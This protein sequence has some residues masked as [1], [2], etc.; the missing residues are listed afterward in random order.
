MSDVNQRNI[1]HPEEIMVNQFEADICVIGSGIA[2][3]IVAKECLDAGLKVVMLE[4][5]SRVNG[6][7][8]LLR[9]LEQMLRDH[10]I[11][12]MAL[13][14][15]PARYGRSDCQ[16]VGNR[17]YHLRSLSLVAR[18]GSTLGWIGSS[19]R[20][21]PEDFRLGSLTGQG[22]DWPLSY[23]DLETYY[24]LAEKTL[25]VAGDECDSGHPPRS[26]P[27]PLPAS[28]FHSRDKPFLD[29]LSGQGWPAMHHN[30]SLAPDGGAFTGDL[31]IDQLEKRPNFK[32]FTR[33]VA[34][35]IECISKN[36]ADAIE[37]L[38]TKRNE[39][40]SVRAEKIIVCA[41]GIE[42]PN[43]L[44]QSENQWWPDGLGN[45]S[46]HLG[47]HLIS[48]SGIGIGG[49]PRGIR[50]NFDPIEPTAITRHF[51]SEKEQS[52]GKYILLWYPMPSGLLFLNTTI[53]QL[54]DERN[55][56]SPG[57]MKTRFGTRKP[58]IDFNYTEVHR[59][60]E[61]VVL[62]H[63][64]DIAK[65]VGLPISHERVYVNAHPMCTTRMSN[66]T[67]DGVVDSNLRI[68]SLDNVYVC[69]SS[70]FTTGG[71]INPTLTVAALAHRL[72]DHLAHT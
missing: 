37:V 49:R 59:K 62:E 28:P 43:L 27:F 44:R 25:Q 55:S 69:G 64:R 48:H 12:R 17:L 9:L 2:G 7:A 21:K 8:L 5:G 34:T 57:S 47:R 51:D 66:D 56:V 6:R 13:W 36:R 50:F 15:R 39:P 42:T 45:H 52:S 4:A 54:P 46:G 24:G 30:I 71:A 40:F 70:S 18:G 16:S 32:L 58:N 14:H 22:L 38:D 35:R 60:R 23:D 63:L 3:A 65:Q 53:E 1:I 72:G 20:H 68:H 33:S 41:G 26:T 11:P 29:F 31:L 19:F 10:R 61:R 67:N